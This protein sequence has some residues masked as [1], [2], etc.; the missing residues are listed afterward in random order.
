[1][2]SHPGRRL[3]LN[4]VVV[5]VFGFFPAMAEI[6][7]LNAV[8]AGGEVSRVETWTVALAVAFGTWSLAVIWMWPWLRFRGRSAR[9]HRDGCR[10]RARSCSSWSRHPSFGAASIYRSCVA[11]SQS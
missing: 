5:T 6:V 2:A 7:A 10:R 8:M 1:V 4:L 9:G 11:G 3:S